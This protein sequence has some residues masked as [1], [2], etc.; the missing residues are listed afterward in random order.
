MT[1]NDDDAIRAL[2]SKV[3]SDFAQAAGM[4]ILPPRVSKRIIENLTKIEMD[5]KGKK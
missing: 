3:N 5:L 4:E 1:V 2:L